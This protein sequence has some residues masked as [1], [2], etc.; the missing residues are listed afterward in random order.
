MDEPTRAKART[1]YHSAKLVEATAAEIVERSKL[2]MLSQLTAI[3][4]ADQQDEAMLALIN[5]LVNMGQGE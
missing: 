4:P 5:N 2:R 1:V 3:R